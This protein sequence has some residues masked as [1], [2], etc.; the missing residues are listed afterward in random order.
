MTEAPRWKLV[1]DQRLCHSS[2]ICVAMADGRFELTATGS[3]PVSEEIAPDEDV[4]DAAEC[5][6]VQAIQVLDAATGVPI[7]PEPL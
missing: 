5:C 7:V 1:V 6:P 2:G 4:I 3:R